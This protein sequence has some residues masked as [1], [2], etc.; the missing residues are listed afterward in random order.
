MPIGAYLAALASQVLHDRRFYMNIAYTGISSYGDI[1]IAYIFM[2][3]PVMTHAVITYTAMTHNAKSY[4][5]M[6]FMS[7]THQVMT[8]IPRADTVILRT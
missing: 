1:V 7:M 4:A 2:A 8:Y 6:V 5:V 3:Y